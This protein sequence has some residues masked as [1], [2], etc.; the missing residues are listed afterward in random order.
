ML[1]EIREDSVKHD[2]QDVN[3]E[4]QYMLLFIYTILH[5]TFNPS[6]TLTASADTPLAQS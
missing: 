5:F 4:L 2:H 1:G 3:T 6:P